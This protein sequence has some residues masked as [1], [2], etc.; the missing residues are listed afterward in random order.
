M[1]RCMPYEDQRL[2]K[3]LFPAEVR[4]KRPSSNAI[5]VRYGLVKVTP[6]ASTSE[7]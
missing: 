6:L 3:P 1:S 5:P 4:I 7:I 2:P